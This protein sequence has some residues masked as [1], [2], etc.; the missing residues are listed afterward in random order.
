MCVVVLPTHKDIPA[1]TFCA[2]SSFLFEAYKKSDDGYFVL[3][4]QTFFCW[5]SGSA[6]MSRPTSVDFI[7][8]EQEGEGTCVRVSLRCESSDSCLRHNVSCAQ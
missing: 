4:A 1:T 5:S 6:A 3:N 7:L 8:Y 2:R